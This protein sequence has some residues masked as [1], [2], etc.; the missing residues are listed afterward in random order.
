[1]KI[2]TICLVLF[3]SFFFNLS[4]YEGLASTGVAISPATGSYNFT[5][6][7]GTIDFTVYNTG[8]DDSTYT[9]SLS[10]TA[11]N[12]TSFEPER[13]TIKSNSYVVFR[14]IVDPNKDVKAGETYT[15]TATAKI[16]SSGNIAVGTESRVNLYFQGERTK[17]YIEKV[18]PSPQPIS[19][20]TPS[21]LT[22]Q[23][24]ATVEKTKPDITLYVILGIATITLIGVVYGVYR[25]A[26]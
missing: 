7:G 17:P 23:A 21:P 25:K 4:T 8:G 9:V 20:P 16:V 6:D 22:G 11:E 24:I 2:T 5:L 3:L 19:P 13:A 15:L 12:F 18:T 10:G 1:M 26:R 14:V